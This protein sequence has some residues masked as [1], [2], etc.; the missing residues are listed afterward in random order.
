MAT[1]GRRKMRQIGLGGAFALK[2]IQDNTSNY[3]CDVAQ[4]FSKLLGADP[5]CLLASCGLA[6]RSTGWR[7]R[8]NKE[9]VIN[10]Q[11]SGRTID[12]RLSELREK[13]LHQNRTDVSH[14]EG[15]M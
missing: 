6:R 13:L 11:P 14:R 8:D 7:L 1:L 15:M 4:L 2:T 9:P 10:L 5:L 12:R 3:N